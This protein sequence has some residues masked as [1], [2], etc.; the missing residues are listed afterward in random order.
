M[1]RY[2]WVIAGGMP[3]CT[4]AAVAQPVLQSG[5]IRTRTVD[6]RQPPAAPAVLLRI[7]GQANEVD[8]AWSGPGGT[9]LYQIFIGDV[10]AG[11]V[12]FQGRA[13]DAYAG[14]PQTIEGGPPRL[15]LQ[16]SENQEA[17]W[18]LYEAPGAWSLTGVRLCSAQSVCNA[19]TGPVLAG[20]LPQ[21]GFVLRNSGPVDVRPPRLAQGRIETQAI[22]LSQA[23][24]LKLSILALDPD[25]GVGDLS[26][27]AITQTQDQI[28]LSKVP[29][30]PIHKGRAVLSQTLAP[31]TAQGTYVINDVFARDAAHNE[32][33]LTDPA[34]IAALFGGQTTFVVGP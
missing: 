34:A 33:D 6:V 31:G 24:L 20:L 2:W 22:S 21:L 32:I 29:A 5:V 25:S 18:G 30:T 14:G 12:Q 1:A 23:P 3:F 26:V 9:P 4:A 28:C 13:D 16:D 27:C 15:D 19:Y 8:F 7:S 11:P 10:Y 17:A